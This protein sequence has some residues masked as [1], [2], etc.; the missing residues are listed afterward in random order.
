MEKFPKFQGGMRAKPGMMVSSPDGMAFKPNADNK[1]KGQAM[2]PDQ[3]T[4]TSSLTNPTAVVFLVMNDACGLNVPF[5]INVNANSQE[6]DVSGPATIS[7]LKEF[8]KSFVGLIDF[9]NY[10]SDIDGVQDTAQ[11][12]NNLLFK[13][14]SL[15]GD[16]GSYTGA[17]NAMKRNTQ[18]QRDLQTIYVNGEFALTNNTSL[19]VS[20]SQPPVVAAT[21]TVQVVFGFKKWL[22]YDDYLAMANNNLGN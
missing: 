4:L 12:A 20:T 2:F 18:F 21:R 8:L 10:Q 15:K 6:F 7:N 13:T 19:G 14:V 9:I 3:I 5:G 16:V 17:V 22:S 11:L 1:L